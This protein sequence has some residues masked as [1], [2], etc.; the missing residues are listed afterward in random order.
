MGAVPSRS[1]ESF[2]EETVELVPSIGFLPFAAFHRWFLPE[3]GLEILTEIGPFLIKHWFLNRLPTIPM[4]PGRIESAVQTDPQL[5]STIWTEGRPVDGGM[6]LDTGPTKMTFHGP[7][8]SP[9]PPFVQFPLLQFPFLRE[10]ERF[11]M[12]FCMFQVVPCARE[13]CTKPRVFRSEFCFYHHSDPKQYL[14]EMKA[15]LQERESFAGLVF[16]HIPFEGF[17]FSHKTFY[18]CEFSHCTFRDCTFQKTS[19]RLCFFNRARFL[20]LQG[21]NLNIYNS[22]FAA[23]TLEECTFLESN[24]VLANCNWIDCTRTSFKD[25]DLYNSRFIGARLDRVEFLDCN[26]LNA[27]FS[28]SQRIETTFKYCNLQDAILDTEEPV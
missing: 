27:D 3:G 23:A 1:A 24:I 22:S 5:F 10:S 18:L 8:V 28:R 13:G 6:F 26:L 11:V 9:F 15:Y 14:Q 25:S 21:V 7:I 17:D 2:F 19:F 20:G 4:T 16:S 12:L